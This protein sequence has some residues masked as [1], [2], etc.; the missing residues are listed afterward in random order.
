[1][2]K[3]YILSANNNTQSRRY[4]SHILVLKGAPQVSSNLSIKYEGELAMNFL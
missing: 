4:L 1:M 2:L 3:A